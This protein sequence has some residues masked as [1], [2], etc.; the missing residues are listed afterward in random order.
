MEATY[1]E[2]LLAAFI[3][4]ALP[5][6]EKDEAWVEAEIQN[7]QPDVRDKILRIRASLKEKPLTEEELNFFKPAQK[8]KKRRR[9]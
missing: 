9:A 3:E 4:S 5:L 1:E 2:R 7:F 8:T 6:D